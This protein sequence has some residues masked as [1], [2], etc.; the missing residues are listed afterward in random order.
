MVP[1]WGVGRE[2][3]PTASPMTYVECEYIAISGTTLKITCELR[4]QNPIPP[5][6]LGL[7]FWDRRFFCSSDFQIAT[8][9]YR[10][11]M[12]VLPLLQLHESGV[13]FTALNT[14]E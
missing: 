9:K 10:T 5:D 3:T 6:F 11:R 8:A 13:G 4:H 7:K 12:R 1:R 2:F 14:V